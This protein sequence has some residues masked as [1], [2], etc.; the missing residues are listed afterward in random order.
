MHIAGSLALVLLGTSR[1]VWGARF[2]PWRRDVDDAAKIEVNAPPRYIVELTSRALKAR[3]VEKVAGLSGLRIVKEFDSDLFPGVSI[4]CDSN[5]DAGSLKDALDEQ[6]G[7]PIVASVYKSTIVRLLPPLLEG[8]SFADDAA[9]LNYSVHHSTGVEKLHEAGIVGEGATIAIVDSGVQYTHPALGEGIGPGYTVI[10]GYDLVGDGWPNQPA[11]PDDD[12]MDKYGHGTHVAGIIAGKS[13]QFVGVAPSAKILSFKVFG[14]GGYSNEETVIE[15]F[16]KAFESGA[17]IITASVGESDGFTSNAWAVLASR[18]VEQGVVVTIAAGN[19]GEDGPF[20]ASNGASGKNVITVGAAE[21]GAFPAQ[22]FSADFSLDGETTKTRIAY[23]PDSGFFPDTIIGWPVRPVTLN[24]SV[25]NDACEP[26]PADTPSFRGTVALA[27]WGGCDITVKHTNIAAFGAEYILFYNDDGP[28]KA[29]YT[30]NK[31]GR[32][33]AIESGAGEAIVGEILAGG[34][35]TASF[36]I[37]TAHYVGLRNAGGGRPARY[38]SWGSTYDLALKPDIVAPGTKIL[39]TFPTDEYRVLSGSSMA[40]PYVAGVAALWVGQFGGRAAHANDPAWAKRL[41]ARIMGTAR[42]VPWADWATTAN[43]YG[44][45]APSTQVGAGLVDAERVLGYT[46][47]LGFA[48]RKFELNDTAH[49]VETQ[50]VDITNSGRDPVAYTFALQ[51]A[52]GYNAWEPVVPDHPQS[53]VPSVK[54]YPYIDPAKMTPKVAFPEGEFVVGPGET[55]T[56]EFTFRIPAGLNTSSLPVYSGKVLISGDNGEELGVPYFGVACDLNQ[57]IT[58]VWDYGWSFPFLTSGVFNDRIEQ[59]SNFTFDLSREAQDFAKLNTRFAW[60]TEELR[61][62]IFESDYA[63]ADWTYP[64]VV[65]QDKYLGSATSW[66]HTDRTAWFEP[67][68]DSEDDIFPFPIYG[69]PRSKRGLYFWL[70]RFAN[71]SSIQPGSYR[72]RIAALR[73]FGDRQVSYDWDIWETPEIT[74]L[75]K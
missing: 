6:N 31:T 51:D 75:P 54:L 22:A 10:G 44:F 17:D 48:G 73:P 46:T 69:Q 38:T 14:S 34:A 33:G 36:D 63:E 16:L 56:A 74:V 32:I 5:Y 57:T 8:E 30:N 12:P 70:G 27:R 28:Y 68:Q 23:I 42:A 39:S 72:F 9:A 49:F 40:T 1:G 25:Q 65:G 71:G 60:G 29:P 15:G 58:N 7:D 55:K 45:W 20:L 59:K 24:S 52:G 4:E 66:S 62:D 61:W 21:P 2:F 26:L 19:A 43:E 37:D 13:D 67:G 41:T 50:V 53:F 3:V 11:T 64:P 35:V 47:E 18:M